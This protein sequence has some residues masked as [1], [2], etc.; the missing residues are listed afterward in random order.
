MKYSVIILLLFCF[1][2]NL[3][4][5]SFDSLKVFQNSYEQI[6]AF[7]DKLNSSIIISSINEN[8]KY[9]LEL[10]DITGLSIIKTDITSTSKRLEVPLILKQGVYILVIGNKNFSVTRKFRVN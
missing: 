3:F 8:S 2:L 9:S 4:S 5:Q 7:Y 1:K 10:F 6:F